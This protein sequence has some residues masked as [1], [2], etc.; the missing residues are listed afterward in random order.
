MLKNNFTFSS[1]LP[2]GIVKFNGK[3]FICPGWHEIPNG[4]EL[5]EVFKHWT[6]IKKFDEA[7]PTQMI[8]EAVESS[9]GDKMYI[10]Q[11]NNGMWDCDCPGFSFRR[12]CK[13]VNLIKQKYQNG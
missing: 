11:F 2:P 1:F 9:K 4:T 6:Q 5:T 7:K 8:K 10:V 3:T 12:I 13:H